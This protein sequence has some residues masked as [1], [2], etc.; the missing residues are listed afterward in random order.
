MR[1]AMSKIRI[2]CAMGAALLWPVAAAAGEAPA[3][4][5]DAAE[6]SNLL[7]VL[8]EQTEIAT[9]TRLNADYVPGMVTVLNG[10]DLELRGLRTVWDALAQVP[11]LEPAIDRIGQRT[12]AVRGVGGAFAS[13]N[14]KILVDDVPMNSALVA[15]ANPVLNLPLEQVERIEVIRGPG[16]AIHGEFAYAGVVNVVTRSDGQRLFGRV[17]SDGLLTGGGIFSW[18]ARD[19]GLRVTANVAGWNRDDTGTLAGPDAMYGLRIPQAGVSNAP[20]PVSDQG[21]ERSALLGLFFRGFSA[22]VQIVEDGRGDY[23]GTGSALPP[24][25]EGTAHRNR[26]HGLD[27]RQELDLGDHW[28]GALSLG[29][30]EVENLVDVMIAPVGDSYWYA[31]SPRGLPRRTTLT[32]GWQVGGY[33]QEQRLDAAANLHWSGWERHDWLLGASWS[34]I[35]AGDSWQSSNV[36][37]TTGTP[38]AAP[39]LYVH[40]D[41]VADGV[42]WVAPGTDRT[43]RSFT[44][45]DEY[46]AGDA[47]TLTGGVRF[48]DYSDVGDNLAPRLAAVWRL[49]RN[50]ILKAQYAQAF[51]PPSF[52]E[53]VWNSAITPETIDTHEFGYIYRD[54]RSAARATL[55]YSNMHDLIVENYVSGVVGYRNASGARSRGVELELERQ[56][57]AAWKVNGNLTYSDTEETASGGRPI[58][59]AAAWLANLGALYQP[60]AA[61]ALSANARH[62]GERPR[63]AGD[64]RGDLKGYDTLDLA[65]SR[66]GL[67]GVKGLTLRAGVSNLFDADLRTPAELAPDPFTVPV[68]YFPSY[69]GDYP[70]AGRSWWLQL[71]YS[72]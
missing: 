9:H 6:L 68:G 72:Y 44:V 55:F 51:R 19:G 66:F 52:Y 16:S 47:F 25:D 29:A 54:D 8:D 2:A 48:D 40:S 59:G 21:Q 35:E 45:Q 4:G 23:F 60:T 36:D 58:P 69:P 22:R 33:Y 14:V 46:R 30:S 49:D 50:N 13:G 17:G 61:W 42:N 37:F 28:K 56:L 43:I 39:A 71:S 10:D 53:M 15:Q 34:A 1:I 38:L 64:P 11:G 7:S 32:D 31:L 57:G 65:G 18:H 70:W 20:G 5:D 62:V 63:E 26:V 27:L 12:V 24:P 3:G 67:G 41:G